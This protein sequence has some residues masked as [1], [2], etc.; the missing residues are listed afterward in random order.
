[1]N[2]FYK[3]IWRPLILVIVLVS[4]LWGM[5]ILVH[6]EHLK[7]SVPQ[8]KNSPQFEDYPVNEKFYGRHVRVDLSSHSMA[9]MYRTKLREGAKEGPNF[10]GHYAL[11]SW[12]CGNECQGNLVIDLRTGKVY[13][14]AEPPFDRALVSSRGVDFRLTSRL[15][16]VDPPCP[17]DYDT[18]VSYGR[19]GEPVRYYLIQDNGLKLIYKIPCRLVNGQQQCG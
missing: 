9:R 2:S 10:A 4:S 17:K 13:G 7:S 8:K 1:M 16:I 6:A 19:T 5:L 3:I 14:L 18:C 12:G 15:I 11:V